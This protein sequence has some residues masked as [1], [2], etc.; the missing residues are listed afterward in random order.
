M[1]N[2]CG[3]G[4]CCC[5]CMTG[6]PSLPSLPSSSPSLAAKTKPERAPVSVPQQPLVYYYTPAAPTSTANQIYYYV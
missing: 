6:F 2:A 1:G 3:C 4:C 5:N